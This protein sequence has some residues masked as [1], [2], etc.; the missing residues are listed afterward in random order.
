MKEFLQTV[1]LIIFFII[2]II[3]LVIKSE[4][5]NIVFATEYFSFDNDL[6]IFVIR[7]LCIL[8]IVLILIFVNTN[9]YIDYKYKRNLS[10]L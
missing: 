4:F 9:F 3:F 2:A 8:L 1:N 7:I 5:L 10:Q 6:I